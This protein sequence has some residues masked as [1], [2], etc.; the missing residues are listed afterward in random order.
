MRVLGHSIHHLQHLLVVLGRGTRP[1]P[2]VRSHRDAGYINP[3]YGCGA[4]DLSLKEEVQ[5][6]QGEIDNFASENE[7]AAG[8]HTELSLLAN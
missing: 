6:K 5:A 7:Q 8:Q 3:V 1:T 4:D 2:H